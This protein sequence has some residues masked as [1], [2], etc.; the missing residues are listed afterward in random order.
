MSL[1]ISFQYYFYKDEYLPLRPWP[2][3]R[4]TAPFFLQST[5]AGTADTLVEIDHIWPLNLFREALN[6]SFVRSICKLID[7]E[8]VRF[9]GLIVKSIYACNIFLEGSCDRS[10]TPSS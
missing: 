10:T 9:A 3:T 5:E 2:L 8:F 6:S 7:T 1:Y 4:V